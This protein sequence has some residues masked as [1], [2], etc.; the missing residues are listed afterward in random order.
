MIRKNVMCIAIIAMISGLM[1][2]GCKEE[3]PNNAKEPENPNETTKPGEA[4]MILVKGGTFTMGN[5]SERDGAGNYY[6]DNEKPAHSVTISNFRIGKYEVTQAQWTAIM[7]NNPSYFEG[8]NLPVENVS[9]DAVQMFISRLNEATGKNYRLP[10]EAEW[11]YAA[12]GSSQSQNYR[13]SGS[14]N[15]DDVAW[16]YNNSDDRTHPVGTKAPNEIGIYDMSGNVREW[17]QDWYDS[18]SQSQQS[19]PTV[20]SYGSNRIGRGGGWNYNAIGCR[21]AARDD[22]SP[23][24]SYHN[25][26]FRLVLP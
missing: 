7:K 18:Y 20:P 19:N 3:T 15:I 11:E 13:Y 23:S 1:M 16:Y 24:Y 4:E 9:W 14:N 2:T 8:D 26:G 10:T 17:C 22:N 5:I 25:L 12:R 21:L 6:Y